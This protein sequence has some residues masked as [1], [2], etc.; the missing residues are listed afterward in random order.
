MEG[1]NYK[2][3][4]LLNK[5]IVFLVAVFLVS[6][7]VFFALR[8]VNKSMFRERRDNI[9]VLMSRIT[10]SIEN[11]MQTKWD[12]L[13]HF[14][15]HFENLN[16]STIEAAVNEL[17]IMEFNSSSTVNAILLFDENGFCYTADGEYLPLSPDTDLSGGKKICSIFRSEA[18]MGDDEPYMCFAEPFDEA[19]MLG[20]NKITHIAMVVNMSFVDVFFD[21]EEFGESRAAFILNPEGNQIYSKETSNPLATYPNIEDA[22]NNAR[23]YYDVTVSQIMNDFDGREKGCVGL[24]Y[25]GMAYYLVYE[26]LSQN[27]WIAVALIEQEIISTGTSG[28]VQSILTSFILLSLVTLAS[29]LLIIMVSVRSAN[30]RLRN[31]MEMEQKA[32]AAKTTF[33]SSMSHDIRTPMNAI[34]G[35]TTLA[36]SHIDDKNYVLNCLEKTEISSRHLLTLINDVLDISKV[37][38]GRMTLTNMDFSLVEQ[39]TELESIVAPQ[40]NEKE[41]ILD[42][43]TENLNVDYV[44]ADKLRLNQIMLNIL[45]NAVKYTPVGGKIRVDFESELISGTDNMRFKYTVKDSGIG[46]SEEFQ[47][48]MYSSFTRENDDLHGDIQGTGLGLTICKQ[49]VDL[50]GGTIDCQSKQ[51]QGTTFEIILDFP[52]ATPKAQS[53]PKISEGD[54]AV[55]SENVLKGI[56]ILVA[57]DNDFNWE[58]AKE[59]L[60]MYGISTYRAENGKIALEM[61]NNAPDGLYDIVLMDIQMPVMNG[62][63]AT[64]AIR[65]SERSYL[66]NIPIMAMTA[67]AFSEDIQRCLEVGM[68]AHL[69]KPI[70]I[71]MLLK[72]IKDTE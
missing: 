58:I 66:K 26:P 40:I 68:N 63:E 25:G 50:M 38:S 18:L 29:I 46:M 12:N 17:Q 28:L 69:S 52:V 6:T 71:E 16:I 3:N 32:N 67:N 48:K 56:N 59:L 54:G 22:L 49:M 24:E 43:H 57:E 42:I 35:M 23:I 5:V 31:A 13:N 1:K 21:M 20:H 37:E 47:K 14:K 19:V 70:N 33:L 15:S 30:R 53:H 41:Q 62:Y 34:I 2:K 72:V 55:E 65:S 9:Q 4:F 51:G 11:S 64:I 61:L 7:S 39:A 45:S 10:L 36:I 8:N 27:D 44:H 60:A